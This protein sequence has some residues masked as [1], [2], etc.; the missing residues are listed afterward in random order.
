MKDAFDKAIQRPAADISTK[1]EL[2][3]LES[4][5]GALKLE[6]HLTPTGT[7]TRQVH[8]NLHEAD[9]RRIAH[10]RERLETAHTQIRRDLP[11]SAAHGR[12]RAD[13]DR[14]R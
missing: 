13:F 1:A 11:V 12:A 10:L 7:I 6:R 9:Q 2:S 5:R 4:Q 14:S 8:Q 3:Q